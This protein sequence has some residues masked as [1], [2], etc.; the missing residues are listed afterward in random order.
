MKKGSGNVAE[1][2]DL[3]EPS[4]PLIRIILPRFPDFGFLEKVTLSFLVFSGIVSSPNRSSSSSSSF[5]K[6]DSD[7]FVFWI[8]LF[9]EYCWVIC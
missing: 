6:T 8:G 1:A 2:V 7:C 9:L 4:Y 5:S 3:P